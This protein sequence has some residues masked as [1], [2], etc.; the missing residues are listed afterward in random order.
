MVVIGIITL[1]IAI[2]MPALAQSRQQAQATVCLSNL[3]QIGMGFEMYAG[4]NHGAVT[5]YPHWRL[6]Q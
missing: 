3:R 4:D 5:P 1:L 6:D 2:L